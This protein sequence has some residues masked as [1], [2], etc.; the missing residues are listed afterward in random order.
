MSSLHSSISTN[1]KIEA[2]TIYELHAPFAGVCRGIR[3]HAGD[4]LKAGEPILTIED[5]SLQSDL[6]SARAELEAARVDLQTVRRGPSKEELN[7]AEAEISRLQQELEGAMKILETNE[8]LLKRDAISRFEVE[9]SRRAVDRL[10][11]SLAAATTHRNDLKARYTDS[12]LKRADSRVEAAKSKVELL[13]G[14]IA[15]SVVRAPFNGT[16]YHFEIKDGA[17]VNAGESLGLF[18]DLSRLRARAFVDE[19][20]LGQITSGAGVTIH[21]DAH[22]D[23]TWQGKVQFIPS[24]VVTRG[25]RSVAEVLCSIE[26][27]RGSLI[28]NVNVD[29]EIVTA[30]G[31][32]VPTLPRSAVF[33]EG[34]DHYVWMIHND[35]A[36]RRSVEVGRGT[37]SLVEVTGGI[38]IGDRVILPGEIPIAEGMKVRVSGK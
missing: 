11:E 18:A 2:G 26:S 4:H 36:V 16:L 20:E 28:P 15:R 7:Q 17:Y 33:L 21:W 3:A 19:P 34:K 14:N 32:K 35:Q 24:E 25:T 6:A 5:P 1:G 30:E 10:R 27:P 31:R 12:D 9:Q 37:S 8:W 13:E 38:A 22:S 23:E 29:I